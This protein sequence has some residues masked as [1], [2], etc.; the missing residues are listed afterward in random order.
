MKAQRQFPKA[1]RLEDQRQQTERY[2]LELKKKKRKRE[3]V[4]LEL[5]CVKNERSAPQL[6]SASL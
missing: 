2:L 4:A 5:S 6:K 1:E 3:T